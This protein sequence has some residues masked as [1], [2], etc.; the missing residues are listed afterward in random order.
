MARKPDAS[1]DHSNGLLKNQLPPPEF[2]EEF[3]TRNFGAG[4]RGGEAQLAEAEVV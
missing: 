2:W 1:S 3:N 4:G